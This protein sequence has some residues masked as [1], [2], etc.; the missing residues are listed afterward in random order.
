[1]ELGNGGGDRDLVAHI[2][3]ND[4]DPVESNRSQLNPRRV[5]VP[6]SDAYSHPL[7]GHSVH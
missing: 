7:G 2:G 1:L 3:G 5:W 6:H 4:R